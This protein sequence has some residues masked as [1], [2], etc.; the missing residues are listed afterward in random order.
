MSNFLQRTISGAVYVG[1]LTAAF[2]LNVYL[3]YIVMAALMFFS[4]YEYYQLVLGKEQLQFKI[5]GF[6]LGLGCILS[7]FTGGDTYTAGLLIIGTLSI[8]FTF[9]LRG[10]GASLKQSLLWLFAFAYIML[11]LSL[12]TIGHGDNYYNNPFENEKTPVLFFL[13]TFIWINDTGAYLVGR[14]LG[15]HPLAPKIS[16]KKTWEGFIG[17]AVLTIT[18]AIIIYWLKLTPIELPYIIATAL[19]FSIFGPLGDLFESSL[20]RKAGVKDSGN[21]IPGH[22]GILDRLDGLLMAFLA[23]A[24]FMMVRSALS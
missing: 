1:L 22:G 21:I 17:G 3:F 16:P 11:P 15:R 23:W 18:A 24:I 13:F 12:I 6:I 4:I 5:L 9:F 10:S 14:W 20:K 19:L 2:F 8:I 7:A